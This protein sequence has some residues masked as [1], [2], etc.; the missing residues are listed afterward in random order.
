[1]FLP[2]LT[3]GYQGILYTGY[4]EFSPLDVNLEEDKFN[5]LCFALFPFR[6]GDET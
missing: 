1:M 4:H 2:N 3:A 5:V 6:E